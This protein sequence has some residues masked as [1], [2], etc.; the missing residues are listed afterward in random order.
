MNCIEW[1]GGVDNNWAPSVLQALKLLLNPL[2]RP[3]RWSFPPSLWMGRRHENML[4]GISGLSLT[5]SELFYLLAVCLWLVSCLS[6]SKQYSPQMTGVRMKMKWSTSK[7]AP[8]LTHIK[9]STNISPL[10]R[11]GKKASE[12]EYLP[13][14][15]KYIELLLFTKLVENRKYSNKRGV[16]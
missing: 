3:W 7:N 11:W 14:L 1:G 16:K 15:N 2:N 4:V 9:G 12:V 6:V 13:L 10:Q 5:N 8:G